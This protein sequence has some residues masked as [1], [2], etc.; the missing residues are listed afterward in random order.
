MPEDWWN[1]HGT[2]KEA[3]AKHWKKP[4]PD[5]TVSVVV[6]RNPVDRLYSAWSDKLLL[7]RDPGFY[8]RFRDE[9]WYPRDLETVADLHQAL[10][11]FVTALESSE[12]LLQADPHWK[13]QAVQIEGHPPYDVIL[14]T[15][16]LGDLLTLIA[17]AQPHLDWIRSTPVPRLHSSDVGASGVM[18]AD[19][20]ARIETLFSDDVAL[21][22]Q[23]AVSYPSVVAADTAAPDVEGIRAASAHWNAQWDAHEAWARE[24]EAKAAQETQG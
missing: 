10:A 7:S 3:Y 5:G 9:P 21:L 20:V 13:P 23:W 8:R 15:K 4:R 18:T 1:I 6:L 22:E 11:D 17:D 12:E 19:L 2:R 24:Q 14:T 16:N